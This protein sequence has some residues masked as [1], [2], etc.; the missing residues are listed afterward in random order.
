M[1]DDQALS[2]DSIV[3]KQYSLCIV[4]YYETVNKNYSQIKKFHATFDIP[5]FLKRNK[6]VV[7]HVEY[8]MEKFN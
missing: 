5:K 8:K 4:F 2:V 3:Q 7:L 6:V 1:L